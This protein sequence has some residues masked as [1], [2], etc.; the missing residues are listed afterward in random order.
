MRTILHLPPVT[1]RFAQGPVRAACLALVLLAALSCSTQSKLRGLQR[2]GAASSLAL[3]REEALP[4]VAPGDLQ[5]HRDTLKVQGPDGREMMIMRA[6]RSEDGEMVATDVIDAAII[7][8]R[9]R[10]VAER[11]GKV[12]L[13]FLVTV[14][15]S[16]LDSR[17]QLRLTPEMDYLGKKIRLDPVLVTGKDYRKAQLRGYQQY[18]RFI[19]SII[20]DTIRFIRQR[21]LEVFLHRNI[22]DLYSLKTDTTYVSDERFAS[23][24]GVTEREA[25]EH[26]TR[27]LAAA[28]N[29][30]KIGMKDRMFDRYVKVP[31]VTEGL[32]LDTVLVT[33]GGDFVYEYVQT[34][35]TAPALRKV[36]VRL[37]GG[38]F[39]EDRGLYSIPE[40]EPL[41][42]YISSLSTLA[43][44]QE[45]YLTQVVGRRVT[46]NST[47]WIDFETGRADINP[48]LGEN[49]AEI[50]R[51]KSHLGDLLEN[52]EFD[53]DSIIVTASCSPEGNYQ[54]NESLSMRRSASVSRYFD[55]FIKS[56]RD[57]LTQAAGLFYSL[58]PAF[59]QTQQVTR[60]PFI[61]RNIA[62]NWEMLRDLVRTDAGI[63]A[64]DKDDF[65]ERMLT[66]DPD[67]REKGL[68]STSYYPRLR[69]V[70]YPRLR[71]V[72]FDF[73]LHRKG[74]VKDTIHTT[75]LDTA[76]MRGLQAIK[77]RDYRTAVTLLRP[78][79]DYNAA[80]AFCCM[81]YNE[82]AL[83]ILDRMEKTPAVNYLLAIVHSRKGEDQDAV[84][85]YLDACRQD[86]S[87]V[88]R[89]NLDPEIS[90]LISRYGLNSDI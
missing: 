48:A 74:M 67:S 12:D 77:D 19:N 85:H 55:I 14:P 41:T 76:Y 89:G 40:A 31:I 29:R 73:H 70:L 51:I 79:G 39:E 23:I 87:Y 68:S 5:A 49:A 10:N 26:Y 43:L 7:T 81:D 56:Y 28:F 24:Y 4:E 3:A 88:H 66:A 83:A 6:V 8:A 34:V 46:A 16:M 1:L 63:D 2:G 64:T 86:A 52:R 36:D 18:E 82:S 75:V 44:D 38:I 27:M 72:R 11:H 90:A 13:R 35:N 80:V 62:E 9:F 22:P 65:A 78:Y 58:D 69:T 57:S 42:F 59:G 32:R 20:T 45:K 30:R 37:S 47:Y 17:W 53:L 61:S 15:K 54:Y 50:S 21:E 84:Q 33:A 71:T 60:I 25:V